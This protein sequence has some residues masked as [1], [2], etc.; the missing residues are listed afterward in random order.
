MTLYRYAALNEKGHE[1]RGTVDA[2]SVQD[3][4][5]KLIRRQ[6][7]VTKVLE[8]EEKKR[9]GSLSKRE[10]LSFTRE[11]SRLIQAGLPLYDSLSA[12]EEKYRGH[13]LQEI[14][15][16]L[17]DQ[18]KAGRPFSEALSK[19]SHTFDLLYCAMIVNAERGG[20]LP[21]ALNEIARLIERQL[22]LQKQLLSAF[23]YPAMLFAFCLVVLSTLLFFVVPTLF[24]LFEGR[25][26]HPFTRFV[27]GASKLAIEFKWVLGGGF[28]LF[29]GLIAWAFSKQGRKRAQKVLNRL[30]LLW[31]ILSKV[32]LARFFRASA[33]LLEGGLPALAAMTQ[34]KETLRHQ[35]LLQSIEG[36]L[37]RLQEG[38]FLQDA[39]QDCPFIPPLVPRMLGIAQTGGNLPSMMQEIAA[40]YEEE[41]E[42]ALSRMTALLQPILLL[43]LGA[44]VGFVLLSVL[45]PLTDV[46]SF[47]T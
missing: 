37:Q 12:L 47:S 15:L 5:Q 45:L 46:T 34:A 25:S 41:L 8:V 27:F 6:V 38:A 4:K 14:L 23:L 13:Q 44:M 17:C 30:P 26:L 32:A 10:L 11:L 18:I 19:Y 28:L 40:I 39:L 20:N 7:L 2:D 29:A 22:E 21:R 16:D 9:K 3:A 33:T 36:A 1:I 42:K 31:P 35:G 24:D 43:V